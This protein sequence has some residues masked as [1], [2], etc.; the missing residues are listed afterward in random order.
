MLAVNIS[1]NHRYVHIWMC[2]R[3]RTMLTFLQNVS[4]QFYITFMT[5]LLEVEGMV[6]ELQLR[7]WQASDHSTRLCFNTCVCESVKPLDIFM[8]PCV[9]NR[10]RDI[11]SS[12]YFEAIFDLSC[13]LCL[14]LP[15]SRAQCFHN[16]RSRIEPKENKV[17]TKRNVKFQSHLWLLEHTMPFFLA[18]VLV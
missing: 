10:P 17:A 18:V 6:V 11:S 9:F 4:Y 2:H 1:A 8:V 13:F 3:P 14:S 7:S 5:G 12:L 15:R 16:I